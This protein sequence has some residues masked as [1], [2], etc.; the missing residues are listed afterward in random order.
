MVW[1]EKIKENYIHAGFKESKIKVV[2]NLKYKKIPNNKTLRSD[3][4]DV[5]ILPVS[6]SIYHQ[7][8]YDQT[9]LMDKSMAILYLY[10]IQRVL[11]KLGV[12]NVRYRL[13]PT[14][15]RSWV[16]PFLDPSFYTQDTESL[17]ASLNRT[18]LV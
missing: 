12:K 13:H 9:I 11:K 3:L 8:E 10:K 6:S 18:T 16:H 5:L 4:T 2:G 15:N 14:L 7:H 1:S 17:D